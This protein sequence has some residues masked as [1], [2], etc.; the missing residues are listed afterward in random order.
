MGKGGKGGRK[1]DEGRK[2]ER[3]GSGREDDGGDGSDRE[4]D[5]GDG[6]GR[7]DEGGDGGAR[8]KA[9]IALGA[10]AGG[11]KRNAR[12]NGTGKERREG[13]EKRGRERAA[14]KRRGGC[15][16][17]R[18]HCPAAARRWPR[19]R[20]GGGPGGC[21][22]AAWWPGNDGMARGPWGPVSL[23]VG[24]RVLFGLRPLRFSV[25]GVRRSSVCVR[26]AS[27]C[28][29]VRAFRSLV[30]SLVCVCGVFVS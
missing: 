30:R 13:R 17:W 12:E 6:S 11:K 25:H 22:A 19:R 16:A 27:L 7:G 1:K 29:G 3:D 26:C 4:D 9:P 8:A 28:V 2:R 24:A 5:G 10:R 23:S 18:L 20:P 14:A 21:P 15:T